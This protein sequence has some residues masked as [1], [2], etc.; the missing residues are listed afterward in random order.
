MKKKKHLFT[1]KSVASQHNCLIIAAS[2]PTF[3]YIRFQLQKIMVP[4]NKTGIVEKTITRTKKFLA[5][6][7]VISSSNK[8][9]SFT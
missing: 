4:T 6:Y 1:L 5:I 2:Q 3:H 7:L 9:T 8:L